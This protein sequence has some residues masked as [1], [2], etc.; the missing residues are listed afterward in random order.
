MGREKWN[1]L[2]GRGADFG[3]V[4]YAVCLLHRNNRLLPRLPR[5]RRRKIIDAKYAVWQMAVCSIALEHTE[6]GGGTA[7]THDFRYARVDVEQLAYDLA[8]QSAPVKLRLPADQLAKHIRTG[9]S[10]RANARTWEATTM[11]GTVPPLAD[12]RK[13]GRLGVRFFDQARRLARGFPSEKSREIFSL[14]DKWSIGEH[15]PGSIHGF[16]DRKP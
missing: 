2:A 10:V 4:V 5:S 6:E 16:S 8:T 3:D 13:Y 14:L 7:A 11:S 9:F 12:L 1:G 15:P